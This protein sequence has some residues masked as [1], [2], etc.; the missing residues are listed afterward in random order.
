M[1][2]AAPRGQVQ[3]GPDIEAGVAGK[4]EPSAAPGELKSELEGPATTGL[5]APSKRQ[6][7]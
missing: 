1:S 6:P 5:R 7:P 4:R 3:D 2:D